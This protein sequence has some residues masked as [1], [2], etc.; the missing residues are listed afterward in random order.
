MLYHYPPWK[1]IVPCWSLRWFEGVRTGFPFSSGNLHSAFCYL[2][3]FSSKRKHSDQFQLRD[4][5]KFIAFYSWGIAKG[6]G[7]RLC[8][9]ES[10]SP[11]QQLNRGLLLSVVGSF[12]RWSSPLGG[13]AVFPDEK[14]SL[15]VYMSIYSENYGSSRIF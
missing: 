10:V 12:V 15:E 11:D 4:P 2:E 1:V 14:G 9:W 5:L 3:S 6:N 8:A 7:R 13:S